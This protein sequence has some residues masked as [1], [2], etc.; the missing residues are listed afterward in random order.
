MRPSASALKWSAVATSDLPDPVGVLSTTC[1][2][3]ISSSS[4]SSWAGYSSSPVAATYDTNRDRISS[5]PVPGGGSSAASAG[6]RAGS[7][8]GSEV[9]GAEVIG[10]RPEV[11]LRTARETACPAT[12][13]RPAAPLSPQVLL[14]RLVGLGQPLG[15]IRRRALGLGRAAV[16]IRVELAHQAA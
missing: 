2:S 10:G 5:G 9:D 1:L 8:V 12:A 13:C 7:E 3:A 14:E 16:Q 6:G 15:L 4:A 11:C